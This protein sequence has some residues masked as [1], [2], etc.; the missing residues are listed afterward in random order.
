M[1]AIEIHKDD[2]GLLKKTDEITYSRSVTNTDLTRI[3]T[4]SKQR[5]D[6]WCKALKDANR[7][8]K[9]IPGSYISN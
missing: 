7:D 9:V 2:E 8:Y 3:G 5:F 1:H 4:D 6:E